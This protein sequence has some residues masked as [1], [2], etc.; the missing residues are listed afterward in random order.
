VADNG[1]HWRRWKALVSCV[2]LTTTIGA[3]LPADQSLVAAATAS[4]PSCLSS[5][6]SQST[7]PLLSTAQVSSDVHQSVTLASANS[8]SSGVSCQWNGKKVAQN[9]DPYDKYT[10]QLGLSFDVYS[11]SAA[12]LADFNSLVKPWGPPT[13][14]PSLG[15]TADL[16]G[17]V[18]YVTERLV[19][20]S[21]DGVISVWMYSLAA[22]ATQESYL[23]TA[24]AQVLSRLNSTVTCLPHVSSVSK[25]EPVVGQSVTIEIEPLLGQSVTITGTCLGNKKPF[26]DADTPYLRLSDSQSWNACSTRD[27]GSDWVKCTVTSWTDTKIV[28]EGT[29]GTPT[30]KPHNCLPPG[31]AGPAVEPAPCRVSPFKPGDGV[32]V[33]VWNPV[34]GAGPALYPTKVVLNPA[35][36]SGGAYAKGT[37][38]AAKINPYGSGWV[39]SQLCAT[40]RV[41]YTSAGVE[42]P[43]VGYF[44]QIEKYQTNEYFALGMLTHLQ[45]PT[46]FALV[47]YLHTPQ[48]TILA[49]ALA[50]LI[51][52]AYSSGAIDNTVTQNITVTQNLYNQMVGYSGGSPKED[53]FLMSALKLNP[54]AATQFMATLNFDQITNWSA[55][56]QGLI[57]SNGPFEQVADVVVHTNM[58]A[59]ANYADYVGPLK[60]GQLAG[61]MYAATRDTNPPP[62]SNFGLPIVTDFIDQWFFANGG[63]PDGSNPLLV[64][65]WLVP[66]VNLNGSVAAPTAAA[67]QNEQDW[68]AG[69]WQLVQ[70][71]LLSAILLPINAYV[72]F[73]IMDML[74][75]W[76]GAG[77]LAVISDTSLYV[78]KQF[79]ETF[80]EQQDLAD[81]IVDVAPDVV[82]QVTDSGNNIY[83]ITRA[84][85]DDNN[86]YQTIVNNGK[87]TQ[88]EKG[89][90]IY[91]FAIM[92][93]TLVEALTR[94]I[95]K[96]LIFNIAGDKVASNTD[97]TFVAKHAGQYFVCKGATPM[98]VKCKGGTPV[99]VMWD[100]IWTQFTSTH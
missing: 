35:D 90:I 15:P 36:L 34:S 62:G 48:D 56:D 100:D 33:Q 70:V 52:S 66:L 94:L 69:G 1:H 61:V 12:A 76:V 22:R 13:P 42:N 72:V 74:E 2:L 6:V 95:E 71:L 27:P 41:C 89:E 91:Y 65:A 20:L 31:T 25:I 14:A 80:V 57:A 8:D 59:Y 40:E 16:V 83:D 93:N 68:L 9:P 81:Q 64:Q 32:Q 86:T 30:L 75:G 79:T 4:A 38:L 73:S 43:I 18:D 50:T 82:K 51:V 54:G 28:L 97:P 53:T 10:V 26:T 98:S 85:P 96:G 87:G 47:D 5:E 55:T 44:K 63:L 46:F 3:V 99:S 23:T 67:I 29:T 77:L 19:V 17:G 84:I 92:R 7:V 58:L 11:T 45:P 24:G 60:P 49:P 37:A 78:A 21:G 88:G 39:I